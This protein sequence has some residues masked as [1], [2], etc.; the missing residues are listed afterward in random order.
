[1]SFCTLG[2]GDFVMA[3]EEQHKIRSLSDCGMN[4]LLMMSFDNLQLYIQ[5]EGERERVGS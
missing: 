3:A 4:E 1:M 5:P 2:N